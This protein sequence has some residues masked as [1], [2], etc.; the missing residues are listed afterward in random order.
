MTTSFREVSK[1][2]VS[3]E[4]GCELQNS[5]FEYGLKG[6]KKEREREKEKETMLCER[7]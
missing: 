5:H 2:A 7:P 1:W 6:E 3:C 4:E